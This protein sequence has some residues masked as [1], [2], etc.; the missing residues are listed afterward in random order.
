MCKP[1]A[2]FQLIRQRRISR[3]DSVGDPIPLKL[4]ALGPTPD[5]K[6]RLS[7][8]HES[9]YAYP[10][11][12]PKIILRRKINRYLFLDTCAGFVIFLTRKPESNH[13]PFSL[14]K[15]SDCGWLKNDSPIPQQ[16]PIY[17]TNSINPIDAL[18]TVR[19]C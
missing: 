5:I 12:T 15:L 14:F 11:C 3:G 1:L 8:C 9:K 6:T 10:W 13:L 19:A 17:I 16:D 18:K 2:S 4:K 7:S